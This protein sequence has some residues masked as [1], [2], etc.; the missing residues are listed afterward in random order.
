MH[1]AEIEEHYQQM[2]HQALPLI[3]SNQTFHDPYLCGKL[4]TRKGITLLARINAPVNSVICEFLHELRALEPEQYYYPSGDLHVTVMSVLSCIEGYQLSVLDKPKYVDLIGSIV[5][6][7]PCFGVEFNGIT[8]ADSGVLLRGYVNNHSL[9]KLRDT[10]RIDIKNCN[11]PHSMDKRYTIV[12]AHSTVMRFREKLQNPLRFADYLVD[13]QQRYFG[14]VD[15][16]QLEL[17][18]NDWYQRQANTDL[19]S[20]PQLSGD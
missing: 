10:L 14:R 15:V 11:A 6:N 18:V 7:T 2:W 4:D 16:A 17:V 20:A 8:L 1:Q 9:E 12:T 3:K 19:L 13:N 5:K